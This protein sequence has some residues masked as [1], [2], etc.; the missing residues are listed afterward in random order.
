[1]RFL[2]VMSAV[3]LAGCVSE[4]VSV[5]GTELGGVAT[6]TGSPTPGRAMQGANEH[7]QKYGRVARPTQLNPF[8][9]LT[10]SCEKPGAS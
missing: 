3:L 8:G 6:W 7:C 2:I 4:W 1:M 9:Y 10:F 5:D